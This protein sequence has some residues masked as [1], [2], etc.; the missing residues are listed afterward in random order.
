MTTEM[1]ISILA[2]AFLFVAI[3]HLI[4]IGKR[5][6]EMI[7]ESDYHNIREFINDIKDDQVNELNEAKIIIRLNH[8]AGLKGADIEKLQVLNKEFRRKF[9]KQAPDNIVA[10]HEN[11]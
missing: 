1:I 3:V 11:C 5:E 9:I 8:L 6:S 7:F 2:L 4:K 10:D